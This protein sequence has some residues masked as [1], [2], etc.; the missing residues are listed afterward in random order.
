VA[1]ITNAFRIRDTRAYLVNSRQ[2]RERS[3]LEE[4]DI[5][6]W[7]MT[8]AE[9]R[10]SVRSL[11][12]V[13]PRSAVKTLEG[14]TRMITREQLARYRYEILGSLGAFAIFLWGMAYPIEDRFSGD[15][16]EYFRASVTI[17]DPIQA[18]TQ[19]NER[20]ANGF[21]SFLAFVRWTL[22]PFLPITLGT[23]VTVVCVTLFVFHLIAITFFLNTLFDWIKEKSSLEIWP[24]AKL[25]LYLYPALVLHTTVLLP[26]TPS[27]DC[28]MLSFALGLRG[29]WLRAGLAL[30]CCGWLRFSYLPLLAVGGAVACI[31]GV[32]KWK[33]LRQSAAPLLLGLALS[34]GAPLM[35]CAASFGTVC[36][37]DPNRVR[38]DAE[39]GRRAGLITARVRWSNVVPEGA[40]GGTKAT[41]GVTDEFLKRNFA[42]TCGV[43]SLS[44]FAFRPLLLPVLVFKKAV[45]LHDNYYAQPYVAD[46]TP[47][48][49][50]HLSRL[51][52]SLS[53]VGLFA[54]LPI[55]WAVWRKRY[56]WTLLLIALSPWMLLGTHAFFHIEP[57]YGLGAV[58]VCLVAGM[59]TA[60]HLVSAA[61]WHRNVGVV[62]FFVLVGLFYWQAGAWDQ[63]DQVLRAAEER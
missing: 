1:F 16:V 23:F 50:R 57:R 41:P 25:L 21:P 51:F 42:D 52:G 10:R 28:L 37:A 59:V 11:R 44:C 43:S 49:Y 55:A 24:S 30:G 54:C 5:W 27:A 14:G 31:D 36:L 63:V 45:A 19:I 38:A 12:S 13:S 18:L 46:S 32:L 53:F 8:V 26:D 6:S 7:V 22:T 20:F 47:S 3:L 2:R 62:A 61:A 40:D 29:H 9:N 48:W 34:I 39:E 60:R 17:H 15:V 56:G 33:R 35:N 58:A 4:A